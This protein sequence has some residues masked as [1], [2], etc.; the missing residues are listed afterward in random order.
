MKRKMFV[1]V[2]LVVALSLLLSACAAG[3][4]A[5]AKVRVA[6]EAAYP[7]FEV[8]RES[9]KQLEGFDIDLM[10]AVAAKAGFEVE[11]ANTPFDSVLAG[12]ATC[13]YDAAISAITITPERAQ[14]IGFSTPYI[15]AGQV[16]T[17]RND[18]TSRIVAMSF[19]EPRSW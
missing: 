9:D 15:N 17:I 11:Y 13:Q 19:C 5:K 1:L 16:T 4:G 12:I 14:K 10:N 8:V 18:N 3:S 6:T 2:S 7:P